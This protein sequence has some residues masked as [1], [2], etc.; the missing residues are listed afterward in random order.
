MEG[1]E[2]HPLY[3]RIRH[4]IRI[5]RYQSDNGGAMGGGRKRSNCLQVNRPDS[6]P[7]EDQMTK[8]LLFLHLCGFHSP[9]SSTD[10]D[11]Q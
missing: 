4:N 8:I 9:T 6:R 5:Y 10:D 3:A 1:Q 11:S 7:N 2:T